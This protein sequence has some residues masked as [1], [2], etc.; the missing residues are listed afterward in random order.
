[1]TPR[2]L[3]LPLGESLTV[4]EHG[5]TYT[6]RMPAEATPT[7]VVPASKPSTLAAMAEV[8]GLAALL[9]LGI[10]G[11]RHLVTTPSPVPRSMP[12]EIKPEAKAEPPPVVAPTLLCGAC[13]HPILKHWPLGCLAPGCTCGVKIVEA[14]R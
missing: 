10:M 11:T 2:P 3:T 12:P 5:A 4:L 1:M 13:R 14:A 6:L 8:A 7:L 9:I